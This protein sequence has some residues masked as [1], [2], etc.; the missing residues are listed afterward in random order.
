MGKAIFIC[1]DPSC[2]KETD[3]VYKYNGE[4]FCKECF[5]KKGKKHSFDGEF[6]TTK[7]KMY[8]FTTDMFNGKPVVVRSRGHYR[9]LL[10]QNG[11]V[12]ASIKECRQQADFR[13]R[14]NNEDHKNRIHAE[15]ERILEKRKSA[16]KWRPYARGK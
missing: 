11:M 6:F 4:T 12:D 8:E 5:Q 10:K 3:T 9:S 2:N 7:D 16:L 15:A 1:S 14:L 13:K